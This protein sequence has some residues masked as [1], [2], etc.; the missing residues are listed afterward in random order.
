M[1][2]L[3]LY[4]P[5]VS[6]GDP[7]DSRWMSEVP[8][9]SGKKLADYHK[10]NGAHDRDKKMDETQYKELSESKLSYIRMSSVL[11]FPGRGKEE[12]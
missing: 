1:S 6:D 7:D 4:L 2:Y 10:K 11:N 5:R 9:A 8:L 3:S 12:T